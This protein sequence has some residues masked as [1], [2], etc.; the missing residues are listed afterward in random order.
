MAEK[1]NLKIMRCP[2]CGAPLK[3][4]NGHDTITCVYCG[5]S[6]VPVNEATPAMQAETHAGGFSGVVR[7]EGIKTSSSALAYMEQFFEEYDWEAFAYAQTLSVAEIDKLANSLKSSSADDKNTWFVCFNAISVPFIHK[8][9]GCK[10]I[11]S[12]VIEEYK[13]DNLDAYSKFDAYKRISTMIA[14]NKTAVVTGLEKIV[15]KA[16]KYGASASEIVMLNDSIG[17]VK[18]LSNVTLFADIEKIPEI[19]AFTQEK[20]AKIV[21]TL[22]AEGIDAESEYARAKNLLNSQKYVEALNI[23]RT[24]K[25]YSDSAALIEKIDKYYLLSNVLEIEGT[26]YY[27]RESENGG[28]DK[29]LDLHPTA[30]G[31]ISEKPLITNIGNIITNYADILYYLDGSYK[32]KKFNLSTKTETTLYKKSLK[33]NSIHIYNRNVYLL[34]ENKELVALDL[35]TGEV[36]TVLTGASKILSMTDNKLA[37]TV[38]HKISGGD[39]EYSAKYETLTKITNVD[40]MD[41]VDLGANKLSI[42]GF[43]N[44]YV[45]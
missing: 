34:A 37:Y 2:S 32:L 35:A 13:N 4:A 18:E 10:Q 11:L 29:T 12:A 43:L 3:A 8:V 17:K 33:K 19:K 1:V 36:K 7:V 24:L 26:L 38:A 5:N 27:F 15:A 45:V 28:E 21:Q 16:E 41:T 22:A 6:I 20:T 44:N 40:T 9:S 42:E 39:D 14:D 25:G 30:D 23:L 31:K